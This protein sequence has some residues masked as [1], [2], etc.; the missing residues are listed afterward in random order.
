MEVID[1]T[2]DDA[3][4]LPPEVEEL[5]ATT[6]CAIEQLDADAEYDVNAVMTPGED[7][8]IV[9][10]FFDDEYGVRNVIIEL[11]EPWEPNGGDDDGRD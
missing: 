6:C 11:D 4:Q 10:F 1:Y 2:D 5:V 7:I 8:A 3:P 9:R